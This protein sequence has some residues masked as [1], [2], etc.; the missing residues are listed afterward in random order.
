MDNKRFGEIVG[1]TVA[2]GILPTAE[3]VSSVLTDQELLE[4]VQARN[5]ILTPALGSIASEGAKTDVAKKDAEMLP[6]PVTPESLAEQLTTAYK[7]YETVANLLNDGRKKK[8][9]VEIV[10]QE[11]V[12]KE[13]EAWA[14]EDRLA[15][16]AK[17]MEADPELRFT[18]IAT[19]N[20]VAKADEII[21][22]AKEFGKNQPYS[23]YVWSEIYGKYTPE[24]LS[25]TDPSN[26]NAV[27]FRLIPNKLDPAM[28]GTVPSQRTRLAQLQAD[29]PFVGVPS[30][31]EDITFWN[32][33]RAT[34]DSLFTGDVFE[35]TYVRHFDLPEKRI[36]GFQYVPRSYVGGDGGPNLN[37]SDVDRDLPARV[38]VG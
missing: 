16:V 38:S 27:K 23:T 29:A 15:Y 24:Q 22:I 20:V 32:T 14:T 37:D 7:G 11:K 34:G 28:Q 17:A 13:L 26:G 6:T 18:L 25:G 35:R 19:P 2:N 33:L 12:A 21:E 5:L 10:D 4:A 3:A 1:A 8:E 30:V 9:H 36:D 31:L